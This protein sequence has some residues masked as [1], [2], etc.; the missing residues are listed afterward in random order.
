MREVNI[1]VMGKTGAGKSTIINTILGN[2]CTNKAVEGICDSVTKENK[3]YETIKTRNSQE[4]RFKLY[5]TVGLE[6]DEKITNRTIDEIEKHIDL[7]EKTKEF[8]DIS[9]V[10]F[11]IN[12][13]CNRLEPYEINLMRRIS[14]EKEIPFIV[15][16]TQ[17]IT[18]EQGELEKQLHNELPK[19]NCIRILARDYESR[20][21]VFPAF[22]MEGLIETSISE[23]Q[24]LKV[25]ILEDKL[26]ALSQSRKDRIDKMSTYA[27]SIVHNYESKALKIGLIPGG[28]IPF[29]HGM[30][31]KMTKEINKSFGL[32]GLAEDYIA[33]F[34]VGL[35][36]TPFMAVPLL[37][38]PIASA[39]V[40][41]VGETYVKALIEV[42]EKSSDQEL[43]DNK[44]MTQKIK[45][46]LSQMQEAK[47]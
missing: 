43:K 38:A 15:V 3:V 45:N 39:Y 20:I 21:G 17:C 24:N 37:S 29:V 22:G 12:S 7:V 30:V 6:V 14:Q 2:D 10:W 42:I 36:A 27:Y 46:Q 32:S 47:K 33:D 40:G 28:C 13:S 4:Y 25:K 23:Y 44:V 26:Q 5:D 31:L 11:C 18:D 34:V 8:K 1:V 41:S 35:I 16:I 9:V 19:N